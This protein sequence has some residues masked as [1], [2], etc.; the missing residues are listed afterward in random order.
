[1]MTHRLL[2]LAIWILLASAAPAVRAQVRQEAPEQIEHPHPQPMRQTLDEH[3]QGVIQRRSGEQ[4]QVRPHDSLVELAE[5][6]WEYRS[7]EDAD[8]LEGWVDRQPPGAPTPAGELSGRA[9]A[10]Q[11][12]E[13][14]SYAAAAQ[15]FAEAMGSV[16]RQEA[17][18]ARLGLAYSLLKQGKADQAIPHL[19][20]LADQGYRPAE[21]RSALAQALMQ[22]GRW[23]EA[24]EQIAQLPAHQRPVWERR[25]AEARL[26]KD[27]QALPQAADPSALSA[28][29]RSHS[30]AMAACIRPDI[31]YEVSRRLAAA[32][33]V[34]QATDIHRRLLECP[35]PSDLRFGIV[36]ELATAL[37][38]EE[39]LALLRQEK[40]A[41]RQA[42]PPRSADIDALELQILKRRMA[43][44]PPDSDLKARIAEEILSI[45]PGDR[46]A[47]EA[48]AWYRFQRKEYEEAEKLFARLNALDPDNKDYALGLGYARLNSGRIDTVL[49]PLE[50]GRIAEDADTRELRE[51]VYRQ[52]A[53]RAYDAKDWD[54]AADYL[55]KLLALEPQDPDAKELLAWTRY[56]QDRRPEAQALMEESFAER[57]SPSLASGLL[58]LYTTEGDEDRAYDWAYRLADDPDPAVKATAGG[59]FF[60]RG[61]P[62]T[63]AQL[64]RDPQR[65]YLNADSPRLEAFLYHRNK[66]GDGQF[67]DLDETALPITFVYPTAPG[68]QWSASITPKHLVGNSGPALP[69]AGRYYRALNVRED[70]RLGYKK[71]DLED[72]LFVVQPDLGFAMEGQLYTEIHVGTTPLNGPVDP[73]PTFAARISAADGYLDLHRC[74]V[75][76][77]ILSYVGQK[78][79]YSN[80]E[81]GRVTRNGI[82]AGKTWPLGGPWWV[83]GSA[84]YDY[85]TGDSV[86]DNQ[87]VHLDAAVGQTLL[88]DRDEFSYGLFFSAQHFRRNSDFY[89]YGHGG[90]Y[91]PEL[92]T[93]IGPF[94]R[95]RT[96]VCRDYWFDVQASAGWLH[97][98]LDSS[99]FYPLF[100]GDTAGFTGEAAAN[101]EGEYDSD[102]D[103]KIGF[104][105]RL[106]GMKLITPHLAAGGF[107]SVN[108]SADYTEWTAGVGIQIFFDP[109]NLFWTRKDLFREFGKCSNK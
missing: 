62:I 15:L 104:N 37:P 75:K 107:A 93:M 6:D 46:D 72:N 80:S 48:L 45:A 33:S 38:D 20:Y 109:Q 3:L 63:A 16:D 29:L 60:D 9:K 41:L 11:L 90:Y 68:K 95:Y 105:L 52:Q 74:N 55:E 2:F 91:S 57:P 77:S 103:D 26:L 71:H 84:G 59:F 54:R 30:E 61:A 28:F 67:G 82:E 85:F 101:A 39:A 5:P 1:M 81:W 31:F 100:D 66:Q 19:A 88:F 98:H 13:R 17:L 56:Q 27:Y 44:L 21:T 14:G 51:L 12:Y 83:S 70:A 89:T 65:C 8:I 36:S 47:L 78:D 22:S 50:R 4:V 40:P 24:R 97:Q 99:P 106:Q 73:T 64:D 92:M 7:P 49:D 25:L 102:T 108:N 86:W 43:A 69:F 87:A 96:A 42:V 53:A 35:L 79:P 10:W 23:A 94:V 34:Q 58:G 32:G 18:N 76:D